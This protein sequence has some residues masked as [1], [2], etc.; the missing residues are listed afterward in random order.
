MLPHISGQPQVL[1]LNNYVAIFIV[2]TTFCF[3]LNL[4]KK[5]YCHV[6]CCC[7]G[8]QFSGEDG[9]LIVGGD[10]SRI[11]LE[12]IVLVGCGLCLDNLGNWRNFCK[13]IFW[14][15]L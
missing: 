6:S 12:L 8:G 15:R 3:A 2:F 5:L 7:Q 13:K 11:R 4:Y 14:K 1:F 9:Q 10:S